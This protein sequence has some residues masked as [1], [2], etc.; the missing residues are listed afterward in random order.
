MASFDLAAN[1]IIKHL[2]EVNGGI[3]IPA[4][5]DNLRLNG[6]PFVFAL[7][8]CIDEIEAAP[9]AKGVVDLPV[10]GVKYQYCF[11]SN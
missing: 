11:F 10:Y 2:I 9:V 6:E 8:R 1:F 4:V 5:M 7:D 3:E